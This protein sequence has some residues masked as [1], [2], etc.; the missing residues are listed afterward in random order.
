[1]VASDPLPPEPRRFSIRLPRPFWLGMATVVLVVVA[2]GLR[3]GVPIYRQQAA[4]REIE[5]ADPKSYIL[6][7]PRGPTWLRDWVGEERMEPFDDVVTLSIDTKANTDAT[8][9]QVNWLTSL[10]S[11]TSPV[12][13]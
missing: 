2:A 12:P 3:I 5:R 8:L 7:R 11:C 13:M 1:M 4:V 6:R 9:R 10:E